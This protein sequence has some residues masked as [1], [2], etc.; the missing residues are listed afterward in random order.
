MIKELQI[1]PF[2]RPLFVWIVGIL[3]QNCF[4]IACDAHWFLLMLW[5]FISCS[6]WGSEKAVDRIYSSRWIWGLLFLCVLLTLSVQRTYFVE[7]K[8]NI[9][10]VG[11][12]LIQF[13]ERLQWDFVHLLEKLNLSA[14][15]KSILATITLGYREGM[16]WQIRKQF[17]MT[18]VAHLLSVSG[19]HV[20]IVARFISL[21]FFF[22][23][24]NEI[25]K[26][27]RYGLTIVLL[28]S[29]VLVTGMA[30]PAIRAA[31]MLTF[32]LTGRVLERL[33]ERY[34]ILFAAAFC[35]LVYN[36]FYLFDIG[37]Q[38]SYLAVF[39]ILYFYPRIHGFI[40]VRNPLLSI[41]WGWIAISLSAQIGTLFLC[42]Y[43]FEQFST[44]FL[45]T[46]LPLTLLATFLIPITLL[47]MLLPVDLGVSVCLEMGVE[48]LTHAL[49]RIVELFSQIPGAT[50]SF[51]FDGIT[52]CMSY[53]AGCLICLYVHFKKITY[54]WCLLI[55]L[56]LISAYILARQSF[57]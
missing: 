40:T 25:G 2:S 53:G 15:E 27:V 38:L 19:F 34:N 10:L 43:Y 9:S 49:F 28:W 26:W 18:G 42:L 4:S 21:C 54:L 8:N 41:P 31:L 36:P 13:A 33:T 24:K 55:V 47:W 44:I 52:L 3:L 20:A 7:I 39:S 56:L 12:D 17:S 37:F 16:D 32:F 1:R 30:A 23:P 11:E 46:N 5:L 22:L 50:F 6:Y 57:S 48:W 35:M 14:E 51:A 45:L 29:F